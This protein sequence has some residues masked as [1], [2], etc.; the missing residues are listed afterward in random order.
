MPKIGNSKTYSDY[1][2]DRCGSK[3]RVSRTWTE[4]I[5]NDNGFMLLEHTQTI[6]TNK[7]C[8]DKF[9]KVLSEET[10][11]REKIRLE[12]ANNALRKTNIKI[13]P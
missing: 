3:R 1:P 9:E 10:E 2:C 5:L 6:C 11:K 4:K 7:D 8:Q 13:S 12:R